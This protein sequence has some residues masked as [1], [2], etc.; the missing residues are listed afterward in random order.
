LNGAK[1]I[2]SPLLEGFVCQCTKNYK[3]IFCEKSV[4]DS[5]VCGEDGECILKEEGGYYCKCDDGSIGEN[6]RSHPCNTNICGMNGVCIRDGANYFCE[7][8]QGFVWFMFL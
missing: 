4:C 3:G 6:C 8:S 5:D 1:C 2:E 7:C